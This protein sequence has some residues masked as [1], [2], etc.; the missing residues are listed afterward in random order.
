MKR[1]GRR[2]R[3]RPAWSSRRTPA[4]RSQ[5]A[6]SPER[7][8]RAAKPPCPAHPRRCD[9]RL[10][11]AAASR[12]P[13]R[14]EPGPGRCVRPRPRLLA[15]T[16]LNNDHSQPR[17]EDNG[18]KMPGHPETLSVKFS[19]VGAGRSRPPQ[20]GSWWSWAR[21]VPSGGASSGGK[22]GLRVYSG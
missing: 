13:R 10:R 5:A 15:Q 11:P 9:P 18:Q 19:M 8:C 21:S 4:L 16:S 14:P 17:W 7:G 2:R 20:G 6:P 22:G 1:G 12:F 3:D